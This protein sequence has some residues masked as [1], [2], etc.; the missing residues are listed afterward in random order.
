MLAAQ[1]YIRL[2]MLTG[3]RRGDMLRLTMS[4][5]REDGIYV[6]PV[7]IKGLTGERMIIQWSGELRAAVGQG[8]APCSALTISVK[9]HEGRMLL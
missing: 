5:L 3:I 1:A 6:E 2:K 8:R 4:N 9:R 7:K